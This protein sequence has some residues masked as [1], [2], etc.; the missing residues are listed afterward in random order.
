MRKVVLR[1]ETGPVRLPDSTGPPALDSALWGGDRGA[2]ARVFG[3]FPIT[4]EHSTKY[5][6]MRLLCT[7]VRHVRTIREHERR[8]DA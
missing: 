6:T 8:F 1:I 2:V 5:R 3:S 7:G 4:L